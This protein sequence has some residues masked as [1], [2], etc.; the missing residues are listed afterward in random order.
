MSHH[1]CQHGQ[2]RW[3]CSPSAAPPRCCSH[4]GGRCNTV[5]YRFVGGHSSEM[6][7]SRRT[8]R[9]LR[10]D[11]K[12][13]LLGKCLLIPRDTHCRTPGG[14]YNRNVRFVTVLGASYTTPRGVSFRATTNEEVVCPQSIW[15]KLPTSADVVGYDDLFPPPS[16]HTRRAYHQT[17]K[18]NA[19]THL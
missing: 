3:G 6:E 7:G 12:D 13:Q 16:A 2:L 15:P 4:S 18:P 17:I 19:V 14:H 9:P 5:H 8:Q 10:C 11:E 1:C